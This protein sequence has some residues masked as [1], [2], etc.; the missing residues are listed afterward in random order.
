MA[1]SERHRDTSLWSEWAGSP[2]E[3]LLDEAWYLA[4]TSQPRMW[5]MVPSLAGFLLSHGFG[6][7]PH[8]SARPMPG[9]REGLFDPSWHWDLHSDHSALSAPIHVQG[10]LELSEAP[11]IISWKR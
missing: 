5:Q 6:P 3:A 10:C 7:V 11:R 2:S 1:Y 4:V 9:S 8:L